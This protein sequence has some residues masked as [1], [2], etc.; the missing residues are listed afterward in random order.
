MP[1]NTI[2]M[3][4]PP[5]GTAVLPANAYRVYLEVNSAQSQN[6]IVLIG[7]Q[8]ATGIPLLTQL[9]TQVTLL[10]NVVGSAMRAEVSV[11]T[12]QSFGPLNVMEIYR[13][14]GGIT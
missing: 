2:R 7:N 3:I 9:S 1:S 6:D 13:T 10:Y 8:L 14:P 4:N 12:V 5:D 11:L